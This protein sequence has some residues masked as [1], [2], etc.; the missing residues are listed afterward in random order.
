MWTKTVTPR[1]GDVDGLR[2]I[3][4][5]VIPA[6][7]EMAREPLFRLFH[8][9]LSLD[10][11]QLIMARISVD[12]V[13]QLRLGA[14]V[15]IRSFVKRIGRTSFTLYQEAWQEGELG[16]KGDAVIVHYDFSQRKA[17]PISA[18]ICSQLKE[19]SLPEDFSDR[20]RSGRLLVKSESSNA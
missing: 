5:C 3:N 1:F 9:D 16:A 4:N 19:H 20:A 11:W 14:D 18:V 7:F 13:A 6:W 15:E 8:S 12:F 17:L 10:N 2:H